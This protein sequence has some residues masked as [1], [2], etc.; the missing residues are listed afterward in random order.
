MFI[1]QVPQLFV[2]GKYIGG[3]EEIPRLHESGKL[4]TILAA[5]N[6]SNNT[7]QQSQEETGGQNQEE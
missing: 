1:F 2:A 4:R 5:L 6:E 7:D 3:E